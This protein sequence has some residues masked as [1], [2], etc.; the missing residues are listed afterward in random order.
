MIGS[1]TDEEKKKKEEPKQ[2]TQK[3]KGIATP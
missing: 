3:P 1:Q 2:K